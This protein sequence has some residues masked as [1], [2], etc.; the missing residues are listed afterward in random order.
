MVLATA[1]MTGQAWG[2]QPVPQV[3]VVGTALLPGLDAPLA[4]VPANVQLFKG[5]DFEQAHQDNLAEYLSRV[6]TGVSLSAA[7]GNQYQPDLNFHGF[8]ASPLLGVPQGL[9]VYQDGVRINEPFGD[10]VNWD[11][12]P[13]SAIAAIELVPGSNPL[14]GLNTLGGTL[15][16]VTWNGRTHPGA[17]VELSR[18]SFGRRTFDAGSGGSRG[19]LDYFAAINSADD[20]GWAEHNPSR[21]RRAFGKFGYRTDGGRIEASITGADNRL[22]GAQT[23]PLSFTDRLREAYTYPDTNWNRLVFATLQATQSVTERLALSLNAYYRRLHNRNFA[24]NVNDDVGEMDDDGGVDTVQAFN[25]KAFIVQ[26]SAGA[27]AQAT[28][29][30]PLMGLRNELAIGASLDIG[31]TAYT[32]DSQPAGFTH[33][34]GTYA[35]GDFVRITDAYTR[36]QYRSAWLSDTLRLSEAWLLTMSAR[37][38]VARLDIRDISG[39]SPRLNGNHRFTRLNP[40]AG[41]VFRPGAALSAYASFNQAARAPTPMELTCADPLDPCKLPNAFLAD[42]PLKQVVARSV[43]AGLRGQRGTL[44]WNL[45]A[46][47]SN[48]DDDIQFVSNGGLT[49]NA[50]YFHNVGRTRRQGVDLNGTIEAGDWRL[51]A[52]YAFVDATFQAAFA[53]NS[54]VNTQAADDGTVQVSPGDRIPAIPRH[55][56]K[57]A[58]RYAPGQRWELG[59]NASYASATFARGDENNADQRGTVPGY[60]LVG[61]DARYTAA[62]NWE[63]F[64]R[65][66]NLFDRHYASLGVLGMNAFATPDRSFDGEH[67]VGEQ[68]R[69]LGTPRT[70]VAGVRYSWR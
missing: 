8:T 54:P 30:T 56:L 44:R 65:V 31:H 18:G 38:N 16:V 2:Q 10:A 3:R 51:T 27:S 70:I 26:N 62:A 19:H 25:D 55:T 61:L 40:A 39:D 32:Q 9:S 6:A 24:S 43:D 59:L 64:A 7:Q 34:R 37:Y 1:A 28:L 14:Y 67:P 11:L 35:V 42:P 50:G 48:L 15:A 57:L 69:G 36:N 21:V 68:F 33:D 47:R 49:S 29:S 52:G 63:F 22:S 58:A 12:V 5:R 45:S 23:I 20:N 41:I 46:Y 66:D 60:A 53:V 4:D 17:F 13:P